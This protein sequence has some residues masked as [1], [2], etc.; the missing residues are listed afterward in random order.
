MTERISYEPTAG[1]SYD[2]AEQKYWDAQGL[3]GEV[4][5]VFEVCHGC[6]MCF[7][8]CDSFPTLFSLIDEKHDGDVRRLDLGEVDAEP[9]VR[10]AA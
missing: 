3:D 7:K 8:Y 1:L 4:R 10:A 6:R 9:E 2:P 5:R